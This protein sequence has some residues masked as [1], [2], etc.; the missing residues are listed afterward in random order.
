MLTR[1]EHRPWWLWLV[2]KP[3]THRVEWW[4]NSHFRHEEARE[5]LESGEGKGYYVYESYHGGDDYYGYAWMFSDK[6]TAFAF[7]IR[8]G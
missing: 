6:N 5:W 1:W 2:R 7:K 8:F 4:K 3:N